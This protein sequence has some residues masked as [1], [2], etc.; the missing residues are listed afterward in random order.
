MIIAKSK[1]NW[2]SDSNPT[3][4]NFEADIYFFAI[5]L[6]FNVLQNMA[7]LSNMSHFARLEF[8]VFV[9]CRPGKCFYIVVVFIFAVDLELGCQIRAKNGS[10]F[11]G[12]ISKIIIKMLNEFVL[13]R[14]TKTA[15]SIYQLK[16]RLSRQNWVH[17]QKIT[18]Q[19]NKG[20]G[21]CFYLLYM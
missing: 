6:V 5:P 14:K 3:Y 4:C 16:A 10:L 12:I 21:S 17:L 18:D 13:A 9:T 15:R 11:G 20:L 2:V 8:S 7:S 19:R 1:L